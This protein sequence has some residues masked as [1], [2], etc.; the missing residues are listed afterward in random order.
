MCDTCS[1]VELIDFM[2]TPDD[3]EDAVQSIKFLLRERKFILVDGNYKLGC[4]KNEQGQWVNDI[5]YCVIKCPDCGQLFSC[6]V[7][8]YRGGGS[9]RKGGFI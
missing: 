5:L 7:N 1:S 2:R 4:P 9:F 6:S 3:F 8:T